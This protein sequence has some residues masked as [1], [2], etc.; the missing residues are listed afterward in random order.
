MTIEAEVPPLSSEEIGELARFYVG[1]DLPV[2]RPWALLCRDVRR[3]LA[4]I[5]VKDRE[6]AELLL[7]IAEVNQAARAS[8][9]HCLHGDERPTLLAQ[10]LVMDLGE[11]VK[12]LE[13]KLREAEERERALRSR[14][15][16]A[17]RE[18]EFHG[19]VFERNDECSSCGMTRVE[20]EYELNPAAL[21]DAKEHAPND[22]PVIRNSCNR[23]DDCEAADAA[24]IA[25]HGGMLPIPN[26]HCH[27]E[28][29]EDC[30]G[31]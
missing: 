21:Q 18:N 3:L 10:C 1:G 4:T 20:Y 5:A 8:G 22:A 26:F 14:L 11:Q 12:S 23:H 30:F 24:Y 31:S 16:S 6:I 7:D 15:H 25:K 9:A 29:C 28:C 17:C 19:R 13:S 27:D 2:H